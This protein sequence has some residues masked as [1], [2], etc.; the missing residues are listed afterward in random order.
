[1]VLQTEDS[2]SA[3]SRLDGVDDDKGDAEADSQTNRH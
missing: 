2:G 1:M 3:F